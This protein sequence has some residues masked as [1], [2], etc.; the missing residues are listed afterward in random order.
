MPNHA[1]GGQPRKYFDASRPALF[2]RPIPLNCRLFLQSKELRFMKFVIPAP[3]PATIAVAGT[4]AVF[5]VRRIWCVGRNYADHAR[6]MGH[7][8]NREPPFF[9]QKP[10]DAVVANNST[11][12]YPPKS[13]ERRVGK[14]CR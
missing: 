14:E 1:L 10:T 9:F 8:P 13:E 12:V 11:L 2:G 6:E 5:P 3:Q 7:D 4:D